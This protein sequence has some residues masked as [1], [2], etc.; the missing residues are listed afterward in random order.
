MLPEKG[1][2]SLPF[3]NTSKVD[4]NWTVSYRVFSSLVYL[5][6]GGLDETR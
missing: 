4:L 1:F 2:V 6:L 5:V 3:S